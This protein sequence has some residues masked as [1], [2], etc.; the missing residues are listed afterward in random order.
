MRCLIKNLLIIF[1]LFLFSYIILVNIIKKHFYKNIEEL[2]EQDSHDS[3]PP[4][5]AAVDVGSPA[6]VSTDTTPTTTTSH[7]TDI[8]HNIDTSDT[9]DTSNTSNTSN[10]INP[11]LLKLISLMQ[12]D[13][14]NLSQSNTNKSLITENQEKITNMQ[15]QLNTLTAQLKP[16]NNSS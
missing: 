5:A 15:N 7:S 10:N 6:R 3:N 4:P 14:E 8:T 9:S 12:Q 1:F 16:A 11:Y 2:T 13:I